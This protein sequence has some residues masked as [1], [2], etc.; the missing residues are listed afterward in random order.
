MIRLTQVV[1]FKPRERYK[2]NFK[3]FYMLFIV[4]MTFSASK[5]EA[6]ENSITMNVQNIQIREAIMLVAKLMDRN[7]VVSPAVNGVTSLYFNH[8]KPLQAFDLLLRAHNLEKIQ[9]GD[10]YF[11]APYDEILKRQQIELQLSE[12]QQKKAPLITAIE[13]IKY[14]S[15]QK[16][17]DIVKGD[18][19]GF[20]SE[21][22]SI[23]VDK[24]TN[25]IAIQDISPHLLIIQKLIKRL[26]VPVKQI[27]IEARIASVDSDCEREL[28]IRFD[29]YSSEDAAQQKAQ[30]GHYSIAVARLPDG[31]ILD[32]KLSALERSGRAELISSPS[33]STSNQEPASIEAGE[34]VPYQ[35]VSESGGTAVTFKKAVLGLKV[36]PEVLPNDKVLL[37]LQINQ[38]RPSNKLVQGVPTINTR[39]IVT[40]ILVK[41]GQTIVLGGIYESNHENG[42]TRI[43]FL[44]QLPVLGWF[45]KD[46]AYKANKRELLIFVTPKIAA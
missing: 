27:S 4:M 40:N 13:Q 3:I 29:A 14:G 30:T 28:G 21:R 2:L 20:I 36:I 37:K 19:V 7:V 41:A 45:F 35:E 32:L 33:L 18:H 38:D 42:E 15:A 23:K 22:G 39:K 24:R 10:I 34:E 5:L 26:D 11:V 46:R 43:P 25:T 44:S 6:Q 8:A 16:I 9:N 1:L 31:S 17:A 12:L